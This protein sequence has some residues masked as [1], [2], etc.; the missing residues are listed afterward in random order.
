MK[1]LFSVPEEKPHIGAWLAPLLLLL[2]LAAFSFAAGRISDSNRTQEKELLSRS[3]ERSITQCYAL[4]GSYPPSLDYLKE[5]YGL[6]YDSSHFFIDYQYIGSN[7][8]PDT[9]IIERE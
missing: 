3:L 2:V 8:R 7:L 9:T 1:K 5:H 4:E 6:T